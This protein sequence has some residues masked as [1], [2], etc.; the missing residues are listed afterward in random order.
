MAR[1]SNPMVE[2][3]RR[4]GHNI[5]QTE[6]AWWYEVQPK[7]LL[8]L[9]YYKTITLG[10]EESAEMMA[11]YDISAI[12]YPTKLDEFG[13]L[14]NITINTNA[15]YDLNCLHRKAR[16]HTRRG[17][18]NTTVE[19][20]EFDYLIES[21][22]PLNRDT[23]E[24]KDATAFMPIPRI[25]ASSARRPKLRKGLLRGGALSEANW[26]CFLLRWKRKTTGLSGL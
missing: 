22:L 23:A 9:P 10:E 20:I 2:F 26:R 25:G 15:Q 7:V 16:N 4:L 12:R 8:A 19:Q 5:I 17:L 21:G 13:F 11:R 6:S 14:S 24:R 3:F 18:E 1:E